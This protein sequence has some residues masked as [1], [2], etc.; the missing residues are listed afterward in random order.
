MKREAASA[1]NSRSFISLRL[2]SIIRVRSRGC[3]VSG[4]KISIFCLPPSSCGACCLA[5]TLTW[6]VA[7]ISSKTPASTQGSAERNTMQER[8]AGTLSPS[9]W[10]SCIEESFAMRVDSCQG[11][12]DCLCGRNFSFG[13]CRAVAEKLLL[14]DRHGALERV[15]A[16]AAGIERGGAMRRADRDEY[17]GFADFEPPK[18]V[19]HRE[20]TD[21][22]FFAHLC[23]DLAHFG[24]GHCLVGFV[25]QVERCPIAGVVAHDA[26]KHDDCSI[27]RRLEFRSDLGRLNWLPDQSA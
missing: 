8:R 10:G 19:N 15:N 9:L 23:T 6:V 25:L 7:A 18:P 26:F 11:E 13:P 22:E 12:K 24:D 20:T 3:C 17:R 4:S 16:E 14:P 1:S 27:G 21:G 5:S 2:E